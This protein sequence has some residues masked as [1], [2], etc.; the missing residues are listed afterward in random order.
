M[1]HAF[2]S[3]QTCPTHLLTSFWRLISYLIGD[4]SDDF[5]FD[6]LQAFI[7]RFIRFAG[8]A[9]SSSSWE[10]VTATSI[11]EKQVRKESRMVN[12]SITR[13]AYSYAPQN[14]HTH[15]HQN[16]N[17]KQNASEIDEYDEYWWIWLS[18]GEVKKKMGKG[19][20]GGGGVHWMISV[21]LIS[22]EL[23]RETLWE[24]SSWHTGSPIRRL[25]WGT[26]STQ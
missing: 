13:T 21:V 16:N 14:T 17:N 10:A 2:I 11:A 23:E 5:G 25:Q 6:S 12:P 20:A 1:Q 26:Q 24:K 19:G 18:T 15:T 9:P 22:T 7:H 4:K 8:P 3:T